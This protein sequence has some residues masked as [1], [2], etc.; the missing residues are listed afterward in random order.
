MKHRVS[1]IL[2]LIALLAAS[3]G[4][5]A[6]SPDTTAAPADTTAASTETERLTV[7]VTGIDY[8]GYKFRMVG[9]DNETSNGWTGIPSDLDVET[10]TGDIPSDAVWARNIA[11]EEALNIEISC[12]VRAST[13]MTDTLRQSVMAGSND[14]D[15]AFPAQTQLSAMVT[16]DYVIDL[17]T[18]DAFD[19]SMPWWNKTAIDA[20]TLYGQTIGAISDITY[21]DKLSTYVTFYNQQI[22]DEYQLGNLYELVDSGKWTLDKMLEMGELVSADINADG[23]WGK[24]DSYGVSCQND[25]AYILLHAAGC[26]VAEPDKDGGLEYVLDDAQTVDV[27]QTIYGLMTDKRRYFNRQDYSGM[28]LEE[29]VEMFNNKRTLFLIRPVQSLFVMRNMQSD[30]GILPLPMVREG[31]KEYHSAVNMYAGTFMCLPKSIEDPE[32][33]GTVLSLM[34][35]ESHYGVMGPLYETVLGNKLLRDELSA[36]ML[37]LA[38]D[39]AVLDTGLL[40]NLGGIRD[41]MIKYKSTDV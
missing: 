5:A 37:D 26:T 23:N 22:A 38:F 2:L 15:A 1:C 41:T 30:F 29:V 6:A 16:G 4:E 10:E 39:G 33:S 12:E 13:A 24:E 35:C 8:G 11:V 31:Q 32:R 34:A 9:Y 20:M 18:V 27:L 40:W 36:K 7:D 14:F 17:A 25:G 19:F 28:A 3:C 21:F